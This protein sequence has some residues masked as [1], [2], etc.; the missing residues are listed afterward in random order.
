MPGPRK[1]MPQH[2]YTGPTSTYDEAHPLLQA[3][4]HHRTIAGRH[5]QRVAQGSPHSGC[6]QIRQSIEYYAS[7]HL[8]SAKL[9][10]HSEDRKG[11]LSPS[12]ARVIAIC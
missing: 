4:H 5:Y 9:R 12:F 3:S 2:H 1:C 7:D 6:L 10:L 11:Q 8:T